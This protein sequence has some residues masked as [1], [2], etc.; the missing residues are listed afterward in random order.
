MTYLYRFQ[1]MHILVHPLDI[2]DKTHK[3]FVNLIYNK[4]C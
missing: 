4:Q 3:K 2:R 1:I